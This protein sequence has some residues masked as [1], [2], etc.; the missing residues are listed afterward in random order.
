MEAIHARYEESE[1]DSSHVEQ[2]GRSTTLRLDGILN[3]QRLADSDSDR[4]S[5]GCAFQLAGRRDDDAVLKKGPT[6]STATKPSSP[7]SLPPTLVIGLQCLQHQRLFS[8]LSMLF[9]S[10]FPRLCSSFNLPASAISGS[11]GYHTTLKAVIQNA[12]GSKTSFRIPLVSS[13]VIGTAVTRGS[14]L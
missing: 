8:Q 12:Q 13:T 11:K 9:A 3:F 6:S 10:K 7:L 14:R 5:R 4:R 2:D 1:A